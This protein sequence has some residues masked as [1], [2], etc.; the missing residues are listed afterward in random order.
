MTTGVGFLNDEQLA[1]WV[2]DTCLLFGTT[3]ETAYKV[4]AM[5]I[6]GLK[7]DL[8]KSNAPV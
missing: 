4:A 1:E 6:E 5:F 7:H 8:E 3:V 2:K